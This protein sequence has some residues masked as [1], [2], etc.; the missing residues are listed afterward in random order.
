MALL[1]AQR[2]S[3]ARG[4]ASL[5]YVPAIDGIRALAVL[6]VILFHGGVSWAQG[7]FLGVDAFFVISGFL[8]GTLLLQEFAK[9]GGIDLRRFWIRRTRRLLPALFLM[10]G[11]V[12]LLAPVLLPDTQLGEFRTQALATLGYVA[13]WAFY[14]QDTSYFA[15]F[16]APSPLLPMWSLGVEEQ[17]YWLFPVMLV[18]FAGLVRSRGRG[19]RVLLGALVVA[20]AGLMALLY[21]SGTSQAHIYFNTATRIQEILV[22]CLLAAILLRHRSTRSTRQRT[23]RAVLPW[24]VWGAVV[25]VAVIGWQANESS[26]WLYLGGFLAF[27]IAMAVIVATVSRYPDHPITRILQWRGLV[28][29][30][31][32]SYG[33]YL[34]HW[35]L[36]LLLTPDATGLSGLLLFAVRLAAVIAVAS[37]SYFLLERPIRRGELR[38]RWGR[39]AGPVA[40]VVALGLVLSALFYGTAGA[41]APDGIEKSSTWETKIVPAA[42]NQTPILLVGDSPGR[43]MGWYFNEA[44]ISDYALSLS[45]MLGCPILDGP[46]VINGVDLPIP[47]ECKQW[48]ERW[49]AA[50]ADSQAEIVVFSNGYWEM[51][52]RRLDGQVVKVGT[53]EMRNR[54]FAAWD[55]VR[56]KTVGKDGKL[57]M[58]NAPCYAQTP[59]RIAGQDPAPV[60]N[61]PQRQKWFNEV[62][63]EYAAKHPD[64]VSIFD[65]RSVLCD[66]DKPRKDTRAD[67][68]PLRRDGVHVQGFGSVA[69]W[70]AMKPTLDAARDAAGRLP[71]IFV[72]DSVTHSLATGYQP[73][74]DPRWSVRYAGGVGCYVHYIKVAAGKEFGWPEECDVGDFADAWKREINVPGANAV[75]IGVAMGDAYDRKDGDSVAKLGTPEFERLAFQEWN[76]AVDKANPESPILIAGSPCR[77]MADNGT[78]VQVEVNNDDSRRRQI[79][80]LARKFA[81][82]NPRVTYLDLDKATCADD[83]GT[84]IAGALKDGVHFSPEGAE[85]VWRT[86]SP[87]IAQVLGAKR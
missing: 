15:Q 54:L 87:E 75:V 32:I 16:D 56:E 10:L 31:L 76:E 24:A 48:Q 18:V 58:T 79:N 26:T 1:T 13:N 44:K 20:S 63:R 47:A 3:Q 42:P 34:W 11:V 45:T 77:A 37:L 85:G 53:P 60:F 81:A 71:L 9:W 51:I 21:L 35:P 2:S 41:K 5:G 57:I 59:Y 82:T 39:R 8:I 73:S 30:G 25:V 66:G 49:P 23:G 27:C 62:Q 74:S 83:G 4:R 65:I 67:G 78:D 80:D 6:A 38:R 68:E 43:F 70:R 7:G 52:D 33:M 72:G 61:D 12:C 22:G 36:M 69:L 29:I 40:V 17:F 64:Q 28:A 14:F 50:V 84:P 86:L 19:L 46:G 55:Q